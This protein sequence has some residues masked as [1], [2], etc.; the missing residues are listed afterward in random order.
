MKILFTFLAVLF[1][2]NSEINAQ[3]YVIDAGHSNVQINVER[4]GVVDVSGR[5]KAVEGNIYYDKADAPKTNANAIIKVDSYDA[6]NIGG[7]S[8]VKSKAFLD[9]DTYPE[10]LFKSTKAISKGGNMYLVGDLTIHGVTKTIELPFSIKGPL[11]DL[12]TQKQSIAFNASIIINR[13]DYGMTFDRKLPNGTS[14][15]GNDIKVTLSILAIA[16]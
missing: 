8:A 1:L 3:N 13:Q 4:F 14:L 9:A 12:P 7:E 16:E 6:N 15:V 11:M 2:S 5:F 10:I